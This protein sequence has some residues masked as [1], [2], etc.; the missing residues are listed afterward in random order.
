MKST[1][2]GCLT[3]F[4]TVVLA[5]PLEAADW[6]CFRGP[7]GS[8]I[9]QDTTVPLT[10]SDS[11]NLKWKAPL[12]GPGAS[13][14]IVSGERVFVTCYS[15]Y[16][17][18]RSNPG[19]IEDLR[20]HLLCIDRN[21]GHVIWSKSVDAVLPEDTYGGIGIPEHGYA[22]NTPVTDGQRVYAFFGKTGVLAFDSEGNQVW[23]VDVGHESSNRRWGSAASPILY[24]NMVIVN[25]SEES[26]TI[27]ALDK[28]TGKEIWK[29]QADGLELS[30][31]TPLIVDLADGK[32]ELV[33][34][35]PYEVWALNPDTGKLGWYVETSLD[36][37]ISPSAIAKDGIVY[38]LGG[39]RQT[40]SLAIRAGGKDDV[41]KTHVLWTSRDASYV[42][43][44]VLH[45]GNLYWVSDQG[46]AYCMNAQT[47][48]AIY[49]E[50][51]RDVPA[52][53][54]M[55]KPFYASVVLIGERLYAVSRKGGTFVLSAKPKFEQLAHNRFQSDESDFNASPAISNGQMFLRSNRFLYCVETD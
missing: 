46:I 24:K 18:E 37:N 27:F 30:Y 49:R 32:K 55:G 5:Y 15:G 51:L 23:Q 14:P 29:A 35:V 50:R 17:V 36:G 8:G 13:S 33:I 40:G 9:S 12:P 26:Q 16:G 28:M 1:A 34:A 20:R 7:G 52:A 19:D 4:L 22:S 6:P 21:D 3:L 54:R 41:T 47:G 39:F 31:D 25:A 43:S 42:P 45:K 10:W 48:E 44:P 2:T 38:V 53:G 11:K